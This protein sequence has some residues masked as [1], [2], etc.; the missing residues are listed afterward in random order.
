[1]T[2]TPRAALHARRT[3]RDKK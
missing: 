2:T 1:M 3:Q